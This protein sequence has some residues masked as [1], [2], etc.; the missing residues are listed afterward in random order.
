MQVRQDIQVGGRPSKTQ[1][2]Y[3]LQDGDSNELAHWAPV[4]EKNMRVLPQLQDVTS[5]TQA[6]APRATL[7]I[8]RDTAARL[9]ITRRRSTTRYTT[10]LASGRSPR[11]SRNSTNITSCSNLILASSSTPVPSGT[12][13]CAQQR[14]SSYRSAH[15]PGSRSR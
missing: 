8:D 3:T 7:R 14:A 4:F 9:G 6:S 12:F 1:Y 2:Q 15:L 10:P 13:M 11:S 5:D